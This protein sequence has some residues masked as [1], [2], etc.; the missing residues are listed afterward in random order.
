MCYNCNGK[1][2][3]SRC[4]MVAEVH[5]SFFYLYCNKIYLLAW[6]MDTINYMQH[7]A[8]LGRVDPRWAPRW[9]HESCYQGTI[10]IWDKS[11]T[12]WHSIKSNGEAASYSTTNAFL[13]LYTESISSEYGVIRFMLF[14]I[15]VNTN[16]TSAS[17]EVITGNKFGNLSVWGKT[18]WCRWC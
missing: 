8:H 10:R 16:L 12:K 4:L 11:S 3:I 17:I 18:V 7:G 9:P 14:E 1:I 13:N 6:N 2:E 15:W 5:F